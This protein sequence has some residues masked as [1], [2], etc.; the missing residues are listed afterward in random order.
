[1]VDRINIQI[2][3]HAA[4]SQLSGDEGLRSLEAASLLMSEFARM[5][6][7][8]DSTAAID[9]LRVFITGIQTQSVTSK[10]L[11]SEI[12]QKLK[13]DMLDAV[14]RLVAARD[15]SLATAMSAG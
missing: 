7:E 5:T 10:L 1:M 9:L 14:S 13:E 4:I 15:M 6:S 3:A 2:A 12:E 11:R 8:A